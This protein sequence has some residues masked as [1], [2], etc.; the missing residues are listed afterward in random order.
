MLVFAVLIIDRKKKLRCRLENDAGYSSP[1]RIAVKCKILPMFISSTIAALY[2]CISNYG[3]C[4]QSYITSWRLCRFQWAD[5]SAQVFEFCI[6]N[7][8]TIIYSR[9]CIAAHRFW[10]AVTGQS[11]MQHILYAVG[12]I[13][14][15]EY[16]RNYARVHQ[17]LGT[18]NKICILACQQL[19]LMHLKCAPTYHESQGLGNAMGHRYQHLAQTL[20]LPLT[21]HYFGGRQVR[22]DEVMQTRYY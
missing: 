22:L 1:A 11:R 14:V 5:L 16:G 13:S 3:C 19:H 8:C 20:L 7:R 12:S 21:F 2:L 17:M 10:C 15:E 4:W 18:L 9:F 6:F